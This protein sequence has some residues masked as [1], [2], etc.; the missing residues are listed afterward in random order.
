L[1]VK[2]LAENVD[3]DMLR[4]EFARYGH[5][6]SAKVM[7]DESV[8]YNQNIPNQMYSFFIDWDF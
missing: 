5:I 4:E 2:N 1:Y 6:T 3:D 8:K 7:K